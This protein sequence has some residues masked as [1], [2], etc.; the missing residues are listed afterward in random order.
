MK[1]HFQPAA[2]RLP[3]AV[4]AGLLLAVSG[5]LWWGPLTKVVR[6]AIR[7]EAYT[8]ILLIVPL[9][10]ALLYLERNLVSPIETNLGWGSAWLVTALMIAGFARWTPLEL[11]EDV[12]LSLSMLALV[13]WWIGSFILCF[14]RRRFQS[15]LFPLCFLLWIVPLPAIALDEVVYFLQQ[16]SAFAARIMFMATGIPAIQ[17]GVMLS[18][19]N[20]DIEVARE[21]SSIRSSM[22]LVITTTVLA[23]LFLR[24]WWR[25]ALLIAVAIPM[26]AIKNGFRIFVITELGTRVDPRFFDG[27]LHH[28]GGILFLGA[29]LIT[30]SLLLYGL[31][32]TET[33]APTPLSTSPG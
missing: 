33:V 8:H 27:N 10:C 24:S 21:C 13:L 32:R 23:H 31:R 2:S 20:L 9:S 25:K 29:A 7:D 22:L 6:L 26:A 12:R 11:S 14:G 30:M 15:L 28:R 19:P 3:I 5:A 17:D 16:Q 4:R 18:I 1:T